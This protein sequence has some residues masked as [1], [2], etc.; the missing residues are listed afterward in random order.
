MARGLFIV[1]EG[2]DSA[3]KTT[4]VRLLANALRAHGVE[5][6]VTTR[7]PGG[8]DSGERLRA[9]LLHGGE[10]CPAAEALA[11]AADRAQHVA[12]VIE[13]AL[14]AG[15]IVI[16]DRHLDSSIAYQVEGR[17][18]RE[19]DVRA[20]NQLAIGRLVPD[21]TV[22]LD[23]PA[24]DAERRGRD[25]GD[26]LETAGLPFHERVNRRYRA[27]AQAAPERYAV[28]DARLPIGRVHAD[29]LAAV[30]PLV[31]RSEAQNLPGQE[32][33]PA[34]PATAQPSTPS[35]RAAAAELAASWPVTAS[36]E[37]RP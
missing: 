14:T 35:A 27:L 19:T 20:V 8:T 28:I 5:D 34:P 6:V 18:L 9:A 24:A 17:G 12:E 16:S 30:L 32:P 37:P 15:A 3:G 31:R 29:V 11:Y 23:I 25:L 13:P 1:F 10:V 2:G 33:A 26:R 22:L 4:Q 7:E 36:Q 21:L